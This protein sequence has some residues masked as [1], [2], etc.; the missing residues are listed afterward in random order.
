M[1]LIYNI[2][3]SKV[4]T[5]IKFELDELS[6]IQP[7]EIQ[8]EVGDASMHVEREVYRDVFFEI[9]QPLIFNS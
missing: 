1:K 6:S 8:N 2:I 9:E 3:T 5:E 7:N 4:H